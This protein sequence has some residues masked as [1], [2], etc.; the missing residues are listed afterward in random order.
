MLYHMDRLELQSWDKDRAQPG[1]TI[2]S[3]L[4]QRNTYLLNMKG[5]VVH[6]WDLPSNPGNHGVLLPNGNL[7]IAL[8]TPEGP[9]GL[10]AKGGRMIEMDWDGNVL[11]EYIDHTQHHD[12][13][14]LPNGHTAYLG[15]ELFDEETCARVQG[16]EPGTE[17]ELGIYGDTITEVDAD[18]NVVWDWKSSRDMDIEDLPLHP[19]VHRDEFSH[20]N[21]LCPLDNGDFLINWRN[22]DAMAIIDRE[23]K[24]FKWVMQDSQFGQ[25]HDAQMLPNGNILFFANAADAFLYGPTLGSRVIELNPETKEIVWQFKGKPEHT[26]YSWFISGAQRQPNG[27][28]LICEGVWGRF[29]EVTP[30]GDIV[31]DYVSP[32][33]NADGSHPAY[34]NGNYVFRCYKYTPDSPEIAGRLPADPW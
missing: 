24:K 16:G 2:F 22:N 10:P 32:Y 18:G 12:S 1:Y 9:K 33:F 28:T 8:N 3:P 21:T 23:T 13:R 17:H 29:F 27:N 6:K 7:Y 19:L 34:Q 30:D 20:A 5:E 25:Q 4:G 14:R 11:W 31:W 15:W 26:F